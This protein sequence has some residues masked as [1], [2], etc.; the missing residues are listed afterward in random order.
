MVRATVIAPPRRVAIWAA[1]AVQD[2]F[3]AFA[4]RYLQEH[5]VPGAQWIGPDVEQ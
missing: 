5:P 1:S 2:C 3:I 4:E